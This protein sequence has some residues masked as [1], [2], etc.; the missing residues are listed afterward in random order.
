M[1]RKL[2]T[3]ILPLFRYLSY[4]CPPVRLTGEQGIINTITS[5]AIM[6]TMTIPLTLPVIYFH[7]LHGRLVKTITGHG[8][9]RLKT[10]DNL[11]INPDSDRERNRTHHDS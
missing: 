9:I 3:L 7:A 11:I 2:I 1:Y 4:K 8:A 6:T 5:I 10:F